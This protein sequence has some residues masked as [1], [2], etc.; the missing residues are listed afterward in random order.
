MFGALSPEDFLKRFGENLLEIVVGLL[1]VLFLSS[2]H[3][4]GGLLKVP[5]IL[6]TRVPGIEGEERV[7]KGLIGLI[8]TVLFYASATIGFYARNGVGPIPLNQAILLTFSLLYFL[9]STVRRLLPK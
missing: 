5:L 3:R 8:L 4:L 9:V 6:P 2:L 7:G 1:T